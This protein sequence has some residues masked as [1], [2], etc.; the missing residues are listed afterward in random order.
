[1]TRRILVCGSLAFDMIA[2]F[3]G[4]FKDHILPEHVPNLSA[5]F[6][7]PELLMECGG[8]ADNI[9]S[10]LALLGAQAVPV[11]T[12]GYDADEY[13]ERMRE[14]GIETDMTKVVPE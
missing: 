12:V 8:C 2:V 9:S 10:N 1:M 5:S 11:G 3:E 6:F 7:V 4:R 13:L 14:L